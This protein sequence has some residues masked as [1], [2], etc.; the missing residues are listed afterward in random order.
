M[1]LNKPYED[2][3]KRNNMLKWLNKA[4]GDLDDKQYTMCTQRNVWTRKMT[5][6]MGW[7]YTFLCD[8]T[9]YRI[10]VALLGINIHSI[11]PVYSKSCYNIY[12]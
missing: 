3:M 5:E 11:T 2:F 1:Q 10:L 4:M 12:I 8:S 7:K 9:H 6:N